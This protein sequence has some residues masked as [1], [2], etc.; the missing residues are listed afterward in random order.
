MADEA[1][2]HRLSELKMSAHDETEWLGCTRLEASAQHHSDPS[3]HSFRARMDLAPPPPPPPRGPHLKIGVGRMAS[4]CDGFWD[5]RVGV[6][7]RLPGRRNWC[8]ALC[9][10]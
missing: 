2:A 9:P 4:S 1:Y 7:A 8:E 5:G 10:A 3:A 6:E